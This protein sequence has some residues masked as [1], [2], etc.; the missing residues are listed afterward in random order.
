MKRRFL[1]AAL[2]LVLSAGHALATDPLATVRALS[3]ALRAGKSA[4]ALALIDASGGYAYSLDGPLNTGERFSAWLQ[5]DIVGPGSKFV[6]ES[7]SVV[8][9]RVDALVMWGRG[10]MNRPARYVFEVRNGKVVSWRMTAR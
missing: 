4:E 7:Q 9:D 10:E 1:T 3:E 5:S 2:A 6:L 8:G